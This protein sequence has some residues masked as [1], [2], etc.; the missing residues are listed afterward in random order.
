M[1]RKPNKNQKSIF[2]K[3]MSFRIIYQG[4]MIGLITLIAFIIGLSTDTQDN[5]YKIEVAQ[6]MAFSVLAFAELVHIFNIRNNKESLFKT[7]PFNNSKLLLAIFISAILMFSVLFIPVLRNIFHLTLL[8]MD[9]LL[10]TI[11]L[12]I[13]P[14]VIVEFM[15]LL[16]I[17]TT[18]D[19]NL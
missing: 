19:E 17:N 7:N 2:T 9:K 18:K 14:I 10:E 12:I 5:A 11:I 15:K 1:E 16:K 8:P 13:S 3:G 6:T 4:I